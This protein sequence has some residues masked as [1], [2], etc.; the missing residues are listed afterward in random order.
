MGGSL[1]PLG[2]R[3]RRNGT[4]TAVSWMISF[5]CGKLDLLFG[6]PLSV[7]VFVDRF[8]SRCG[9]G[10]TAVRDD[11]TIHH[12]NAKPSFYRLSCLLLV[13][14][15]VA[16]RKRKKLIHTVRW[17]RVRLITPFSSPHPVEDLVSPPPHPR[18]FY[19]LVRRW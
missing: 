6:G 2:R 9:R 19:S 16:S 13:C 12:G 8:L 15:F 5:V 1:A 14:L 17:L 7:G 4:P 11:R 10:R 3:Q 18:S